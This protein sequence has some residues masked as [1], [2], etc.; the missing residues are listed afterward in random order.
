MVERPWTAASALV[1]LLVATK[2]PAED[3]HDMMGPRTVAAIAL[4]QWAALAALAALCNTLIRQVLLRLLLSKDFNEINQTIRCI[5]ILFPS[6][7]AAVTPV[8]IHRQRTTGAGALRQS[9]TTNELDL[10]GEGSGEG[11]AEKRREG[12]QLDGD[13]SSPEMADGNC[14]PLPC[15]LPLKSGSPGSPLPHPSLTVSLLR[16]DRSVLFVKAVDAARI[17]LPPLAACL[18]RATNLALAGAGAADVVGDAALMAF[19]QSVLFDKVRAEA[20]TALVAHV[21][22]S[23]LRLGLLARLWLPLDS[24]VTCIAS[25]LCAA[26]AVTPA[27][28]Q[29]FGFVAALMRGVVW[30]VA[31]TYLLSVLGVLT[32]SDGVLTAWGLL[33]FGLSLSLQHAAKDVVSAIQLFLSRPFEVGD[34]VDPGKGHG[35]GEVVAVNLGYTTLRLTS[36]NQLLAIPNTELAG[37]RIENFTR[38]EEGRRGLVRVR[39]A[40]CT[41]LK[42]VQQVS[43]WMRGAAEAVGLHVVWSHLDEVDERGIHYAMA[44]RGPK[45]FGDFQRLREQCMLRV[46]AKLRE[47]GVK[48]PCGSMATPVSLSGSLAEQP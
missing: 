31:V 44:I 30:S 3:L 16:T 4:V 41:D 18:L 25:D 1:A 33:G 24:A 37:T 6:T 28:R 8:G 48:M 40:H 32:S 36:S 14:A 45:V 34:T 12:S 5:L 11:E 35:Q 19:F 23:V 29:A 15:C 13:S 47:H 10:F 46:L 7:S 38:M 2:H 21:T 22:P 20:T 9:V 26:Y 39:I 27:G 43:G 17:A 42:V